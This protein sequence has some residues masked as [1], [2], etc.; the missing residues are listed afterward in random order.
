MLE[1]VP[2]SFIA[3]YEYTA[4]DLLPKEASVKEAASRAHIHKPLMMLLQSLPSLTQITLRLAEQITHIFPALGSEHPLLSIA[5]T[6][7]LAAYRQAGAKGEDPKWMQTR[8]IDALLD[9]AAAVIDF[10]VRA[11][12]DMGEGERWEI[13]QT[14]LS[15]WIAA[16]DGK[17]I[18]FTERDRHADE[19]IAAKIMLAGQLLSMSDTK[20]LQLLRHSR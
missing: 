15:T 18:V 8:F 6:E 11:V 7:A 13:L 9:R 17:R 2:S 16:R 4:A 3:P 1:A 10:D 19:R 20:A 5:L 14:P 12:D